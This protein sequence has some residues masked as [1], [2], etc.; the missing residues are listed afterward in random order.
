MITMIYLVHL[1][2]ADTLLMA[3][4][5]HL[6]VDIKFIHQIELHKVQQFMHTGQ[7]T[8][9]LALLIIIFTLIVTVDLIAKQKH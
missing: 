8:V 2:E 1:I 7:Q 3:G 9:H 6:V 4:I 5:H